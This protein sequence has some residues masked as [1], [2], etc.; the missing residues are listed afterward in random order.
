MTGYKTGTGNQLQNDGTYTYTYDQE[1]NLTKKSKGANADTWTYGYDNKDHMIWARDA[2]SDGGSA[3]MTATYSYDALGNRVEKDVWQG[4]VTTVTRFAYDG[5]DVWA[6]LNGSNAL[7]TRYIRG[8]HVDHLFASV[9]G[10]GTVSWQ[11]TDRLG[12]VRNVTNNSGVVQDTMTYDGYGNIQTETNGSSGGRYKFTGREQ[13]TETGLQFNRAR[14]YDPRVGRWTSQDPLGFAAGD[15]NLYRYVQN[16][17]LNYVDSTGRGPDFLDWVLNGF[18]SPYGKP[19]P[20]WSAP[21]PPKPLPPGSI[22]VKIGDTTVVIKLS[23]FI[24]KNQPN[25]D[26]LAKFLRVIM[27]AE[28]ARQKTNFARRT[29]LE[30]AANF[31]QKETA[32][33]AMNRWGVQGA[34]PEDAVRDAAKLFEKLAKE[35]FD[36]KG[37]F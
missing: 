25:G 2:A 14:Y 30:G 29:R 23:D 11:L 32:E 7:Q 6:D 19:N 1:G 18:S 10:A 34:P 37:P 35:Q 27:D 9:S 22:R 26:K 3:T 5:Q 24:D 15:A 21:P 20:K 8:D 16:S 36:M 4:G 12:S 31:I 28:I 33:E 17:P 13:D